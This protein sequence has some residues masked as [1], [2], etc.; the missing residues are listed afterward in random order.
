MEVI[1]MDDLLHE[2]R[3]LMKC[4]HLNHAFHLDN[5]IGAHM[6]KVQHV[7][8]WGDDACEIELKKRPE[9][10]VIQQQSYCCVMILYQR[11]QQRKKWKKVSSAQKRC[12]FEYL[13]LNL[14]QIRF[15]VVEYSKLKC[16]VSFY[17]LSSHV[18]FF[19]SLV[20]AFVHKLYILLCSACCVY[21]TPHM[22]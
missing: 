20:T 21:E 4:G 13:P 3:A 22:N 9:V 15:C 12:S 14:E 1:K 16:R 5:N 2:T 17:S 7:S 10:V 8:M 18:I 19:L 11:T 6:C